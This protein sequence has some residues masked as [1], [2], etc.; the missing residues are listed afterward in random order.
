MKHKTNA[1]LLKDLY[2]KFPTCQSIPIDTQGATK[3][4]YGE[5]NPHAQIMLVGEAPGQ[6]EDEL[7]RPFVGRSGELLTKTL[8]SLGVE[9]KD[10]F[11]TNVVK[12]RPPNNRTPTPQEVLLYKKYFLIPEIRI[13]H[14]KVIVAVGSIAFKTLLEDMPTSISKARGLLFKKSD[15]IIIPTYHPA[16]ILR[17][18]AAFESFKHDLALAIATAQKH[19]T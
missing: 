18:P 9:R 17:N 4:V 19:N 16:Y 5:G 14:P 3:I 7:G 6:R 15:I 13:I 12:C 11:I 8:Q 10:V 2:S 1:E